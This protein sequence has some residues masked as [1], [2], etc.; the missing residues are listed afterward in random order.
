MKYLSLAIS[1]GLTA[2][3]F[4]MSQATGEESGSMSMTLA[5]WISEHFVPAHW[6]SLDQLHLLIRKGAH[7]GEYAVLGL[8]Y[9]LT[10]RLFRWPTGIMIL[11]GLFIAL[12]DEASQWLSEGRGPSLIDALVFDFPGFLLGGIIGRIVF[13]KINVS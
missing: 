3:I 13:C 7:V 8:S 5:Q 11:L 9:A 2:M 1:L 4:S 10:F 6:I 12:G